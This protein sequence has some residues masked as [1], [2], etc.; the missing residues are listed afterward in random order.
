MELLERATFLDTLAGYAREARQGS[1]RLVLVSGESGMGKTALVEAFQQQLSDARWL[2]G[3]CDGLLTPRPLGPLFDIGPQA[4][5]EL[6]ERCR[7]GAKATRDELF[8]AF[9]AG[10]ST[11]PLTTVVIEDLHW[12]D[13]A[14]AD[15]LSFLGRRLARIPALILA[16]YRDDELAIDHPVR[17]VLGDLAT[18]RSTRRIRIPPLSVAA[19]AELAAAHDADAAELHR[20]TGGNPFYVSEILE[21]GWPSVPPTVRDAVSARLARAAPG[22]RQV[23]EAASVSRGRVDLALLTAAMGGPGST[24]NVDTYLETGLLVADGTAVR[25]RHELVRMAVEASLGP[26]RAAGLHTRLLTVLEE[27]GDADPALLA[28]HAEGAGDTAAIRRHA[29]EAARRSAVLSAHREAVAHYER[30]LRFTP[31]TDRVTLAGLHEALAAEYGFLDRWEE[32]ERALRTALALRRALGDRL[33][34][35]TILRLLS[36]TLWRLCRGPE[37]DQAGGEAVAVLETLPPGPE[38]AWAYANRGADHFISGRLDDAAEVLDRA[39]ALSEKLGDTGAVCYSLNGM[40]HTAMARGQDGVPPL[41]RALDLA[42][43]ADLPESAARSYAGLHEFAARRNGF[44]AA[45]RLYADGL[46]YTDGRELGVFKA[47]LLG[48]RCWTLLDQGRWDEAVA[49]AGESL[50]GMNPSPVNKLNPLRV[51]ALIRGR[52]GDDQGAWE[53]LDEAHRSGTQLGEAVLLVPVHAARAELHWLAG[54][55][56]EVVA[57]AEAG[58]DRAAGMTDPWIIG[59]AA[60]WLPRLSPSRAAD[61]PGNLPEPHRLE[62]AGDWQ[63]AAR[64]WDDLGRPYDAA[65]TRLFSGDEAGLR[66][67]HTAFEELGARATAAMTR[68]R[69]RELGLRAIPRGPRPATK[70]APG[71]LTAREQEVLVLV[72]EGLADREISERLFISERTV[73]HHVSALLAKIGVSSRTAAA[74]KAARL[75]LEPAD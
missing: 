69:M 39:L 75:G 57:E 11:A 53:L 6:A 4:G 43:A 7:Q 32:N 17:T 71:G 51:L 64:A 3:A 70:A 36:A 22:A 40:A 66:D 13:E 46:A 44:A 38:L 31:D 65:L 74:R 18:Q 8:T 30:A 47:C 12:A 16:T 1:G 41:Q 21:A 34:T 23:V 29:P 26:L 50:D 48:W 10:L 61:L 62:A 73:N 5:G 37:S 20:V 28:H 52:R 49:T 33:A 2:W 15:L 72:S 58:L 67:A 14:T 25:F 45:E 27:R 63:A 59:S 54:H 68:R 35:G 19:V 55:R 42:L 9:L 56:D 60:I 24:A